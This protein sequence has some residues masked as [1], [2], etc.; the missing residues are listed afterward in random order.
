MQAA[1]W[2]GDSTP[3][4]FPNQG[5]D[6]PAQIPR[7]SPLSTGRAE[8]RL[9]RSAEALI[10]MMPLV[11]LVLAKTWGAPEV[12]SQWGARE[13]AQALL[14]TSRSVAICMKR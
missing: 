9:R 11:F 1:A 2:L 3:H 13:A 10:C 8:A 7:H 4:R 12:G 6:A 14:R 5:S